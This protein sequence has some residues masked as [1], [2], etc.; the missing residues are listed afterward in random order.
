MTCFRQNSC[1]NVSIGRSGAES[2]ICLEGFDGIPAFT[3]ICAPIEKLECPNGFVP[4]GQLGQEEC[5]DIDE[6]VELQNPCVVGRCQ[7]VPGTYLCHCPPGYEARE[8]FDGRLRCLDVN[9]C[10]SG[11]PCLPGVCRNREGTY[12]CECPD[13]YRPSAPDARRCEAI[14]ICRE[15]DPCAPHGTC[16]DSGPGRYQCLCPPGFDFVDGGCLDIDECRSG[17]SD[18]C[19]PGECIN[20]IGSYQCDCPRGYVFI[21]GR[22]IDI[23][24]CATSTSDPCRPGVC[25]NIDGGYRCSCPL[26]FQPSDGA[27]IDVDE[28]VEG[29]NPCGDGRGTCLNTVGAYECRC[30]LGFEFDRRERTCVDVN[31]CV[32]GEPCLPGRCLNSIGS[33][34]CQC[35]PGYQGFPP[36]ALA[37][38]SCVDINE[39]VE[40]PGICGPGEF[41]LQ[42]FVI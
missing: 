21:D 16:I 22:C 13:G 33:Y 36:G 19:R 20:T 39:C 5:I 34:V 6:C 29:P 24:E 41:V 14:F 15:G 4:Q 1:A 8:E 7:N 12:T 38:S 35:P 17:L 3:G 23:N 31:E 26:G 40:S 11:N 25:Q 27:C 2:C 28:C 18:P 10:S 42:V 30:L 9:E 32:I 37:P